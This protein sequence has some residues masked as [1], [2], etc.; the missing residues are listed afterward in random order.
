MNLILEKVISFEDEKLKIYRDRF[1]MKEKSSKKYNMPTQPIIIDKPSKE[2]VEYIDLDD[3]IDNKLV[4]LT[5]EGRIT[6]YT[7]PIIDLL[8]KNDS[9]ATCFISGMDALANDDIIKE[10]SNNGNEI[11]LQGYSDTPFTKM[12]LDDIGGSIVATYNMLNSLGVNPTNI[13]RPPQ[14]KLNE[15]VKDQIN[16]P[17]VLWSIDSKDL[18]SSKESIKANILNDIEEGSIIRLHYTENTLEALKDLIPELKKQGYGF[19]TLSDMKKKYSNIFAPGKVYAKIKKLDEPSKQRVDESNNKDNV[20]S[21]NKVY[22][23]LA[24]VKQLDQAA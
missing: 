11:G 21:M 1:N 18:L 14:G 23:K 5:F 24:E 20:I 8:H 16:A 4:S 3:K 6:E 15:S 10:I 17:L 9:Q 13:V 7:K 12:Q 2:A 22:T 19:V